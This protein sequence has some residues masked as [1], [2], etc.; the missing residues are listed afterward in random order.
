MFAPTA[1]MTTASV[2]AVAGAA[3]LAP[4]ALAR[5]TQFAER[6]IQDTFSATRA[7]EAFSEMERLNGMLGLWTGSEDFL[8]NGV[9]SRRCGVSRLL[10]L[11]FG[12]VKER[13]PGAKQSLEV[14]GVQY[15]GDATPDFIRAAGFSSLP[16]PDDSFRRVVG[17]N[18]GTEMLRTADIITATTEH[19]DRDVEATLGG[20]SKALLLHDDVDGA[21]ATC[22][23]W[24]GVMSSA[25]A[26]ARALD[27]WC[28]LLKRHGNV[29]TTLDLSK[30]A[31]GHW[32]PSNFAGA[33]VMQRM[34][35]SLWSKGPP[36][37]LR[38]INLDGQ[39]ELQGNVLELLLRDEGIATLRELRLN[40][41][42]K[43]TG[44]LPVSIA[45]C[46]EL[47]LLDVCGCSLTG[48]FN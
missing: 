40:E 48:G 28:S 41:C 23:E 35:T 17:D 10:E 45:C 1:S 3:V 2:G 30:T 26:R 8:D 34:C 44:T 11:S 31:H 33:D 6:R 9:Y 47:R 37:R 12:D 22:A 7:G 39:P 43:A 25:R 13:P 4:C 29:A 18:L 38:R 32:R 21:V 15:N 27:A 14:L 5:G 36:T 42:R 19:G 20:L 16:V 46:T 24:L